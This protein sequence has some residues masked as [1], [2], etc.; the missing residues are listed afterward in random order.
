MA[1]R[2]KIKK[3]GTGAGMELMEP[4]MSLDE[5]L[6]RDQVRTLRNGTAD[7][8]KELLAYKYNGFW[9][10]MD[11]FKEKQTLDEMYARGE[12]PWE[13]WKSGQKNEVEL[14]NA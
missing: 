4:A 14:I 10:C 6:T 12:A 11:T 8:K 2:Y 9:A 7:Q 13:V 3:D 5:V 1:R